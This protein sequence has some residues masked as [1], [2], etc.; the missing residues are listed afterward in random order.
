MN[1]RTLLIGGVAIAATTAT[2]TA[3]FL[4]RGLE[5]A[6]IFTRDGLAL[7][8][9]DPVTYF[10][11]AR[12]IAGDPSH[13]YDWAGATWRFI[14]AR[15][16]DDFAADP[17]AFAPQYGGFCAWTVAANG[18]LVSTQPEN[19]AIVEERLFLHFDDAVQNTWNTDP[20]GFIRK[21]DLRWPILTANL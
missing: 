4:P 13:T 19:W 16:R 21:A 12:P 14:S 7:G 3:V 9:T 15:N 17:L 5:P 1:R 6:L 10:T 11:H 20:P 2:A 8:G 18:A